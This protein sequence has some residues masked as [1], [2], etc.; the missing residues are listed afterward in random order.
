MYSNFCVVGWYDVGFHNKNVKSPNIDKLAKEGV[1][2]NQY[3]GAPCQRVLLVLE[4]KNFYRRLYGNLDI[5]LACLA[6]KHKEK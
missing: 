5:K 3:Y 1:I 4:K 2:L 6:S